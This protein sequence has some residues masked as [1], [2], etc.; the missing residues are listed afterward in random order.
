ML[1]QLVQVEGEA[2]G[3]SDSLQKFI[4]ELNKGPSYS[5]VSQVDINDVDTVEGEEGFHVR[6][7]VDVTS[8]CL[9]WELKCIAFVLPANTLAAFSS[10]QM[11]RYLSNL[12]WT[13]KGKCLKDPQIRDIVKN[14]T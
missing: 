1:T 2:Q 4:T 11:L 7:W 9:K 6:R 5:S 3:A 10:T 12:F 8:K 13:G 14:I